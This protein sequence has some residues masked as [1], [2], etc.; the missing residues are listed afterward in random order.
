M[1]AA[2]YYRFPVLGVSLAAR[3]PDRADAGFEAGT[4]PLIRSHNIGLVDQGLSDRYWLGTV[5]R[6]A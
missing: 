5:V 4:D 1:P 3:S 6:L 2:Y